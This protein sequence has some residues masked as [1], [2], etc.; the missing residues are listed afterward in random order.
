[1]FDAY[2]TYQEPCPERTEGFLFGGISPPN[3][4]IY[5]Q[6]PQ[7]LGGENLILDKHDV[8]HKSHE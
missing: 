4:K 7:R 1:L 3:K 5:S 2:G 8:T 6:R